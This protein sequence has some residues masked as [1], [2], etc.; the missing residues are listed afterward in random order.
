MSFNIHFVGSRLHGYTFGIPDV[1][2]NDITMVGYD[3]SESIAGS[4]WNNEF[5]L[6]FI[7][8]ILSD[9]VK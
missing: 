3:L 1:F 7:G 4:G 5:K 6:K 8:A 2:Q 9:S